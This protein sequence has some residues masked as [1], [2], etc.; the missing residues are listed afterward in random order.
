MPARK[1]WNGEC[2]CAFGT[3][4]LAG[5]A[6]LRGVDGTLLRDGLV[7]AADLGQVDGFELQREFH[8]RV[9]DVSSGFIGDGVFRQ[10]D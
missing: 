3:A 2:L 5:Q 4:A 7:V 1:D 8:E 6:G 9:G 10:P